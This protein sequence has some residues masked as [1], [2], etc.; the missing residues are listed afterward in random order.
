MR[1][2]AAGAVLHQPRQARQHVDRR[3]DAAAVEVARQHDLPL[4]DVAGEVRDRMPDV[5]GRHRQDR[6]LRER[7]LGAAQAARALEQRREVRVHVA[8]EAL[9]ARDLALRRRHFA[10]RFGVVRH[11]GEDREHVLAFDEREVLGRGQREARR[12]QALRRRVAGEIEEQR[13][14]LQ[15][16][17]LLQAA[18]EE[19]GAVVGHADAG[20]D[21]REIAALCLRR[22]CRSRAWPAISTASRSCGSPP[23]E[24]SGSFCPRTRLF[25]RSS[26]VIA[27]LDEVA[28]HRPRDRID[29]QAVDRIAP[30]APAT[31]GP[32]SI[33]WPTPLNTR[34]RMPGESPNDSG[35]PMKRTTVPASESPDVDS[36]TS[37][38]MKSRSIAATRPSRA[39]PSA[40]RTSTASTGRRRAC[41]S[42]TAAALRAASPRLQP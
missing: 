22:R 6:Q 25:I 38:V 36:S 2:L 40:P 5:V 34:P 10:Q 35:S 7:A 18:A 30:R 13:G 27:G 21:D 26:V 39:R 3:I 41:A 16:A 20:E 29:R 15:R 4:G 31:G 8:G 11:V 42:G 12:Q 1:V 28:R 17:A 9:A 23:P 32:P 19:F 37:I 33:T 24:K 14:A